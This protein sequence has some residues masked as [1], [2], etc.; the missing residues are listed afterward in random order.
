MPLILAHD[1]GTTGNKATLFAVD[2]SIVASTFAGYDTSYAQ[3]NWA[4]QDPHA[5]QAALFEST[6]W[7]IRAAKEAGHSAADV[8]V[9]SFSGHMNGALLVDAAG[10]PLR[11]A[12]IWA[13]QRATAQAEPDP[14]AAERPRSI[15][16]PATASAR[17]TPRPSCCGSSSTSRRSTAAPAG[18]CRPRTTLR[19]S[20]AAPSPPTSPT[21]R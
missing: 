7:L 21:P 17:P 3:P 19:S 16:L 5:W 6:Q 13:D 2:G 8:A 15:S 9:V 20:S 1:L 11:P 18:C 14:R 12:I 4:E 10:A